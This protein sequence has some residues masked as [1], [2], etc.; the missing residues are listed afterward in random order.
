MM[1][2]QA[3]LL[4]VVAA[5]NALSRLADLLHRRQQQGDQDANDGDDYQKL[6]QCERTAPVCRHDS[7]PN[8][9]S[10]ERDRS[11]SAS[12]ASTLVSLTA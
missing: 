8:R 1:N 7:P 10:D 6:N 11:H 5:A 3:D 9:S 12:W 4:E 2:G